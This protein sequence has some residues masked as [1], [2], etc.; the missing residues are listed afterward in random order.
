MGLTLVNQ[1]FTLG[2][3][4]YSFALFVVPWLD[5]SLPVGYRVC[6]GATLAPECDEHRREA[7]DS[8]DLTGADT[9][10]FV[11]S[12]RFPEVSAVSIARDAQRRVAP[13]HRHGVGLSR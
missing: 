9:G 7:Q 11:L 2:I 6:G 1:A 12:R 3:L 13:C 5:A 8:I 4:I 10:G